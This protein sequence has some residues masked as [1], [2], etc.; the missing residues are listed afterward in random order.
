MEDRAARLANLLLREGV[1]RKDDS[2]HQ[3]VYADL[4]GDRD[5]FADVGRRLDAVG[6]ELVERLGHLGVRLGPVDV[7][8]ADLRNRMGLDAGH[9][10][11]LVYLWTQLVYR[12]WADLRHGREPTSPGGEQEHL[13]GEEEPPSMSYG[14][15]RTEFAEIVS[16]SRFK[17]ALGRLQQLRFVRADEAR[18]K[19]W[20]DAGLYVYLDQNRMEEFVVD[21]ARRLGTTDPVEAVAQIVR[22][23]KVTEASE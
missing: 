3:Q 18:D 11:L 16:K 2:E 9:I 7:A 20:A 13:F 19:V 22:G 23:T 10:R 1:L 4:V 21:L 17:G 8:A 5:L 14:A 15:V 12:E 6:Y